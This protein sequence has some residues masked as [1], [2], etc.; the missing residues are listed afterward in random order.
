[1]QLQK[2][3]DGEANL[4][5]IEKYYRSCCLD[6]IIARKKFAREARWDDLLE[7]FYRIMEFVHIS[8]K[9]YAEEYEEFVTQKFEQ[10]S[11]K[12]KPIRKAPTHEPDYYEILGVDRSASEEEIKRAFRVL[13][14]QVHP[15]YYQW[16]CEDRVMCS[17]PDAEEKTQKLLEAYKTLRNPEKRYI[18]D[19]SLRSGVC[20]ETGNVTWQLHDSR[21]SSHRACRES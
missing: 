20:W 2:K 10:Q 3:T 7:R 15:D 9:S 17:G 11:Q 14:M 21:Q 1:M 6:R 18:Y 8:Y 16:H 4:E 19:L 12:R 13:I 5:V